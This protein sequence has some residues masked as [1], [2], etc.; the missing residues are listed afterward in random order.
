MKKLFVI[1]AGVLALTSCF[2]CACVKQPQSQT[3]TYVVI[4][5]MAKTDDVLLIVEV[6]KEPTQDK[7]PSVESKTGYDGVWQSADFLSAKNGDTITIKPTYTPKTYT[8]S[9]NVDGGNAL[10]SAQVVFDAPYSLPTPT[11]EGFIFVGWY[12]TRTDIT[13]ERREELVLT[14][15]AKWSIASSLTLTAKWQEKIYE[16]SVV[17]MAE[18]KQNVVVSAIRGKELDSS[19]IPTIDQKTGYTACWM[20]AGA[21]VDFSTLII[22]GDIVATLVYTPKSYTIVFKYDYVNETSGTNPS[23]TSL[24]NMTVIYGEEFTL[25]NLDGVNYHLATAWEIDGNLFTQ[26]SL[27]GESWNID[28]ESQIIALLKGAKVRFTLRQKGYADKYVYFNYGEVIDYSVFPA[29]QG[30]GNNEV[31]AWGKKGT[32]DGLNARRD[33]VIE[34]EIVGKDYSPAV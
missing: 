12:A 31:G 18:G 19:L 26:E 9:F 24:Q 5:D 34:A 4:Y 3:K 28:G 33:Y 14:E 8:V 21:P 7:I 22:E 20:V 25:P 6:G 23:I 15:G 11:K 1:I 13:G 32:L 16:Q 10:D 30:V 29:V 27:S 2:F 17:F